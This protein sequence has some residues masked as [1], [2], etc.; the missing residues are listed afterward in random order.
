MK[1]PALKYEKFFNFLN[2]PPK[3]LIG[4]EISTSSIKMTELSIK[5]SGHIVVENFVV[6]AVP[7]DAFNDQGIANVDSLGASVERAWKKL[8]TRIK[9]VA[10]ALPANTAITKKVHFPVEMDDDQI[11]EE[12]AV[13][14]SQ[15]IP[16]PLDEVNLDWFLIGPYAQN[17]EEENEFLVC[18]AR[19]DILDDYLAVCQAAGLKI[20]IADVENYA[21]QAAFD[22]LLQQSDELSGDDQAIA[23]VDA[24]SSTLRISVYWQGAPLY[25]KEIPFGANQ[26][27]ESIASL[28]SLSPEQAEEAKRK[29]G[30]GLDGYE[31]QALQPFLESMA[32]GV[33]RALQFFLTQG[34]VE[35]IDSIVL[36]GGCATFPG[37]AESMEN[38]SGIKSYIINP[39]DGMDLS[40]KA[41][42][43]MSSG[44]VPMLMTACGLALRRFD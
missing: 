6:E 44:D 26:L 10:I 42:A 35:K 28:Y 33:N 40:S 18:A 9:N 38:I 15:F 29:G 16:F 23:F 7:R 21:Q 30:A 37:A 24:G 41:K 5:R 8:G 13:E 2:V 11:S 36:A 27:T 31:S 39:F 34:S 32:M 14:A 4:L 43:R 25:F 22:R 19:K 3:P 1:A 20:L 17:P 12:V